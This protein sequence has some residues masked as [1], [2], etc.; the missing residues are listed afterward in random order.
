MRSVFTVALAVCLILGIAGGMGGQT[1]STRACHMG[2]GQCPSHKSSGSDS[3]PVSPCPANCPL[4][5]CSGAL[6]FPVSDALCVRLLSDRTPD[7]L[8]WLAAKRTYPPPL[9]PP[10]LAAG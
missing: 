8:D 1:T 4:C 3:T 7:D 6:M 9:P 2:L 5:S 10:R